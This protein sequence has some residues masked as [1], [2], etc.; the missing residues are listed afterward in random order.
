MCIF[1]LQ[2][3]RVELLRG[4]ANLACPRVI[5]MSAVQET[6]EKVQE[7][8]QKCKTAESRCGGTQAIVRWECL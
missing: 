8:Q 4:T 6:V 3:C 5:A 7:G 2:M 1:V